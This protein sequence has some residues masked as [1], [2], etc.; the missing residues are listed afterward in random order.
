MCESV[1]K[2][3]PTEKHQLISRWHSPNTRQLCRDRL[4][5][6]LKQCHEM[7]SSIIDRMRK[8]NI[9]DFNDNTSDDTIDEKDFDGDLQYIISTD[10]DMKSMSTQEIQEL[11]EE[12]KREFL[13][14]QNKSWEGLQTKEDQLKSQRFLDCLH[15]RGAII[16][17]YCRTYDLQTTNGYL[18]CISCG[19][20]FKTDLSI[21]EI[22]GRMFEILNYHSMSGCVDQFP[23][24]NMFQSN[25]I[26][27][28]DTCPLNQFV[29]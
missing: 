10:V 15:M 19:I 14:E 4:I 20:R 1:V 2:L 23:H 6:R 5:S 25:L 17:P 11:T 28:C 29:L 21:N 12:V 13:E 3:S 7:R 16:C 22:I 18:S 24:F 26:I 27:Y 8:V 9:N